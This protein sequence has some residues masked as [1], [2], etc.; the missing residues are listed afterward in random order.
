AGI[1]PDELDLVVAGGAGGRRS[2]VELAALGAL[3]A[4]APPRERWLCAPQAQWG[5][6]F[7]FASAALP[8]IA[9]RA[10]AEGVIPPGC[11]G[12]TRPADW[13]A[14]LGCAEGPRPAPLARCLVLAT[15]DPGA[16]AALVLG[17]G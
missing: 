4:E 8:L 17:R 2:R 14:A 5:E 9:A 11:P 16:A 12:A 7:A 10:L 3:F 1:A 13:P 15:S 6:G